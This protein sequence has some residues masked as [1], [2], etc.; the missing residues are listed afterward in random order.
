MTLARTHPTTLVTGGCGFIGFALCRRL[1]LAG[2]RVVAYDDLS[3]GDA[4]NLPEGATLVQGD[5]RDAGRFRRALAESA[6]DGVIHLAAMHYLPE[7][8]AR[9]RETVDINVEGTRRVLEACHTEGVRR[10]VFASSAAVYAPVAG[11]CVED[12]TPMA[13]IEVYG[14]SKLEGERL[15]EAFARETGLAATSARIFNA[16]GRRETNPHVIPHIFESLRRADQVQLGNLGP[17]RDYIDTRD[18]ADALV[19]LL[20]SSKGYRVFNVGTGDAHSVADIIAALERIL[21]RRIEVQQDPARLRPV[22]R[23]LLVADISRIRAATGWAPRVTLDAALRDL[24]A[25]Y[26]FDSD[27]AAGPRKAHP[28]TTPQP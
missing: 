9:P 26:G 7:C 14:E 12:A 25:A 17:R 5:V 19:S 8:A 21:G 28:T 6:A 13:P 24:V 2:H 10:L 22:E 11:R 27:D 4:A 1:T 3:R 18:V 20:E 16:V 15:V 23:T